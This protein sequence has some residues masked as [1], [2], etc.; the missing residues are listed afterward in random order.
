MDARATSPIAHWGTELERAAANRRSWLIYRDRE[1]NVAALL[2]MAT[3][4]GERVHLVQSERRITFAAFERLVA[5][6]AQ[7]LSAR[8]IHRGSRVLLFGWNGIDWV[9]GFWATLAAGA[10]VVLGNAWWGP[11]EIGHAI[12]LTQPDLVLTDS[13]TAPRV[14]NGVATASLGAPDAAIAD[15]LPP[16][17]ADEDA[18]AVIIFTS[19]TSGLPKAVVLSHRALIAG[20][21]TLLHATGLLPARAEAFPPDIALVSSPLFHVGGVQQILR[22]LVG[23]GT[24]VFTKGRFDPAEVLRLIAEERVQRWNGVPTMF[25]RVMNHPDAAAADLSSLKSINVGG[26]PVSAE[27]TERLRVF[28]PALK[29]RISTGYGLTESGGALTVAPGRLAADHPG[30]AGAPLPC[31]EIT[32]ATPD[33]NG[34]GEILVRSPTLMDGYL[35]EPDSGPIDAEGRLHTGD[36][37]RMQDGVLTI[38]GRSKDLIIRGGENIAPAQIEAALMAVPGVID[39]AVVGLP[40]PEFG[41]I[42]AAAVVMTTNAG[43]T[44]DGLRR[45]VAPRLSSFA[46]PVRWWLRTAPLPISDVGK[47]DK[48]KLKAEWPSP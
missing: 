45:V 17:P 32:I 4:W 22:A 40:D 38:T 44:A 43:M 25:S 28:M 37:G 34:E 46:V 10:T 30:S 48:K 14:G 21:Q 42:V 27:F 7:S 6:K 31:V 8:G 35:G 13:A 36:L 47:V 24:F 9:A 1:R 16:L 12:A 11:D 23:G 5:A 26:A 29:R 33:T 39:A 19:G 2:K 3:I 18:P 41:E 15:D 20:L